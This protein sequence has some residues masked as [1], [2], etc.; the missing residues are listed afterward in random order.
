MK[1]R[2]LWHR[3]DNSVGLRVFDAIDEAVLVH[4]RQRALGAL[5]W[6]EDAEGR[7]VRLA[8]P[9]PARIEQAAS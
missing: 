1:W 4:D 6:V 9:E 5:A 7:T 3:D 8:A 2:V